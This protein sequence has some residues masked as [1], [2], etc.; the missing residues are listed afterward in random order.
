MQ[1]A[2]AFYTGCVDVHAMEAL[3]NGY[4]VQVDFI[5]KVHKWPAI[6]VDYDDNETK[7]SWNALAELTAEYGLSFLFS[8]SIEP[9]LFNS[10]A[11]TIYVS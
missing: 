9:S 2:K 11:N 10:E 1:K 5:N 8:F 6:T 7:L 4:S 3:N